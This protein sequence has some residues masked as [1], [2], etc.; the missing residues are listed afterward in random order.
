[1]RG[2]TGDAVSAF[3]LIPRIALD[4][5][6]RHVAGTVDPL[7]ENHPWYVLI[8]ATA[9]VAG[10]ALSE[11]ME[12]AL[13]AAA[14]AGEI[15]DAVLAG[16]E[17]QRKSLWF[18]REAIVEAQRF[19]GGSIKHDVSVPLS[20][21]PEF[22][23]RA[24]AA[25]VAEMPGLRPCGFGHFGDGNI[26]FNLTQPPGMPAADFL[27]EW[28]RFNRIVHDI[29]H[30]LDGSIAAEHGVGLIKRDELER[31]GDP[32]GLDLMRSL[33]AALDPHDLLNPGKVVIRRDIGHPAA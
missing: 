17:A 26:H 10:S 19:E 7:A 3:E 22:L 21:L 11:A 18:I 1:M 13:A 20:R 32:V 23:E 14:E 9:G 31:Y 8:E 28:G 4:F 16:T 12:N 15:L 29:V 30:A 6:L 25:C 24:E 33:K 27:A 5:A 2:A